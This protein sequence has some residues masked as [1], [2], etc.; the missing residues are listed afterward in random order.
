MN[1]LA[2]IYPTFGMSI[3]MAQ[4]MTGLWMY[5]W[6]PHLPAELVELDEYRRD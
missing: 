4:T 3:Y 2:L 1:P 5:A 6:T